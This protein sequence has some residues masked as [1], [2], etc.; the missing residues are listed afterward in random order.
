M[1]PPSEDYLWGL[2]TKELDSYVN[3]ETNR[4]I[5]TS[6]EVKASPHKH[7]NVYRP[8]F[9]SKVNRRVK[10]EIQTQSVV[11]KEVNVG[12]MFRNKRP[13]PSRRYSSV[14]DDFPEAEMVPDGELDSFDPKKIK[15][16]RRFEEDKKVY[17]H[18]G[19]S[20]SLIRSERVPPPS[21]FRGMDI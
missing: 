19:L 8:G 6:L 17:W 16:R 15:T 20:K 10:R 5:H 21:V 18:E 4:A 7:T 9:L 3:L 11:P 2:T 12:R 14:S 13:L 1:L